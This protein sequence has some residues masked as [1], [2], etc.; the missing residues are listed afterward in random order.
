VVPDIVDI[1][2]D[3]NFGCRHSALR[4][5]PSSVS[6]F[7]ICLFGPSLDFFFPAQLFKAIGSA[8]QQSTYAL[9]DTNSDIVRV[10]GKFSKQ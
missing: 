8:V 7:V 5:F 2:K 10:L 6:D 4:K 9:K 3:T 1:L